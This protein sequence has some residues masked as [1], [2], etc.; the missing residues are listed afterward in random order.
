M[1]ASQLQEGSS[2]NFMEMP[3]AHYATLPF[4]KVVSGG[5]TVEFDDPAYTEHEKT[6]LTLAV[7]DE[8]LAN[9][10]PVTIVWGEENGGR[11]S[12][13]SNVTCRRKFAPP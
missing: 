9:G 10:S 6:W 8:S 1:Y 5:K 3:T 2:G 12:R 4:D 7:V 13:L 11:R